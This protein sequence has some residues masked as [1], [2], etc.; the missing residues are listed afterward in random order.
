MSRPTIDGP[1]APRSPM[2]NPQRTRSIPQFS[3]PRYTSAAS[4]PTVVR[5]AAFGGDSSASG[6]GKMSDDPPVDSPGLNSPGGGGM[7]LAE[8]IRERERAKQRDTRQLPRAGPI[9]DV[10]KQLM[11]K[12]IPATYDP[13]VSR[14]TMAEGKTA[15][16]E[17]IDL[18]DMDKFL[19]ECV[20][21]CVCVCVCVC[22]CDAV[23]A[24]GT[25]PVFHYVQA[26]ASIRRRCAVLY[27]SVQVRHEQ[28]VPTY[29]RRL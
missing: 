11:R 14:T 16:A 7:S 26:H 15:A 24:D 19:T 21:G 9:S 10:E 4:E 25:D 20:A 18:S 22:V 23:G 1:G 5:A 17:P 3:A 13:G 8:V 12:G 27:P 29:V 2:A 6:G 28:A